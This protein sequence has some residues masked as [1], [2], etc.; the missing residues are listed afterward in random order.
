MASPTVQQINI[1][2]PAGP[3]GV[4]IQKDQSSG[5]C[6][7]SAKTNQGSPL[8]VG[9]TILTLNGT[10]LVDCNGGINAWVTLFSAFGSGERELVVH[11]S[12]IP[13]AD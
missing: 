10:K 9:D 7:V 4:S 2:I 3:L 12:S 5:Q 6:I 8:Q 13:A 11:R 1:S